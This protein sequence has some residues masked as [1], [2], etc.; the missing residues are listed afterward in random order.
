MDIR[1]GENLAQSAAEEVIMGDDK[2]KCCNM[3][4]LFAAYML[5]YMCSQ[6]MMMNHGLSGLTDESVKLELYITQQL[7]VMAGFI[8]PA[9]GV[10]LYDIVCG[11]IMKCALFICYVLCMVSLY[12]FSG[13]WKHAVFIVLCS[14]C[15][16]M[17]GAVVYAYLAGETDF[18]EIGSRKSIGYVIGGG[19]ALALIIQWLLNVIPDAGGIIVSVL[20]AV[21]YAG[22]LFRVK[23]P[24]VAGNREEKRAWKRQAL[25]LCVAVPCVLTLLAYYESHIN[26]I[27]FG[28]HFYSSVRIFAAVGYLIIGICFGNA[29][30]WIVHL[31]MVC[32]SLASV[33]AGYL[34]IRAGEAWW[35]HLALFYLVLGSIVAYYNLMFMEISGKTPAPVLWASMGRIMD[36]GITAGFTFV[37]AFLPTSDMSVLL[38]YMGI[39]SVLIAAMVV[40]GFLSVGNTA[41]K[42]AAAAGQD[43]RL[44]VE[45]RVSALS[46]QFGLTP[47]ETEVL[48]VLVTTEYKNQEIADRL[49]ISRRQLQNHIASIYLKTGANSRAGLLMLIGTDN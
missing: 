47:R 28:G 43:S 36:A 1:E 19:G 41:E 5:V 40:G 26:R 37:S 20:M 15:L 16:G 25:C 12:C 3:M 32:I 48:G 38:M 17:T 39:L 35:I 34:M 13:I 2:K 31:M 6:S 46:E 7:A 30:R 4:L 27:S 14:L 24:V 10:K 29:R 8:I 44:S 23:C 18:Y 21:I 49:F 22:I 33:I 11:R 9:L 42:E 45:E